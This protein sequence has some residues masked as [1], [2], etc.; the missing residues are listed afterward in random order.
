MRCGAANDVRSINEAN[1]ITNT[2]GQ[3]STAVH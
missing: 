1:G 2:R 3:W